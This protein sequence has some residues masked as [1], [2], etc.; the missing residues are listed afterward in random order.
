[1]KVLV[2]GSGGR[3]HALVWKIA[4]SPLV[5]KIY[6]A[7]G[8]AGIST[9][10]ECVN[11]SAEDIKG[12][13]AFAQNKKI[14]LTVVGPETPLTLGIVDLF[15]AKKLSIFGPGKE[16][17][18]IEGSKVFAK[19]LM[20]KYHIPT[21]KYEVFTSTNKA[22][23]YLKKAE[24]PLVIKADGLAAG[25]GVIVAQ[26]YEE[27]AAAV[28]LIIQKKAFG[29]AGNK[30]IIEEFLE[31]EEVSFMAVTDG[32][33]VLPLATSQDHKAIFDGDRGPNT[34][35]MGAYSPAP[36]VTPQLHKQIMEEVMQ[37]T[38]KA[39]AAEG[40][41]Y[42]G[43]LY[44]GLIIKEGKARVLEFNGRFGDPEAQPILARMKS[45]LV[46]IMQAAIDSTLGGLSIDWDPRP[47]VCVVMASQGYPG[48]YEKGEV[49]QGLATVS[50]MKDV[51]VFHAGTVRKG[52]RLATSG[53]RVLGVTALGSDI[54]EA[55]DRVY[56]ATGRIQWEGVYFRKDIGHKALKKQ[57]NTPLVGIVMGSDSDLPIMV[58]TTSVL[59]KMDI[60]YELTIASAHRSPQ[61][62]HEYAQKAAER[63]LEI[64]IAGAGAAAHL[65]GVIA[66]E[67]T[68]PVIGVPIN[69]SALNGLDSLLSTVQM[70]PGVPVATMAIGKAGAR[71]A[72]IFAA[73]IL[74]LKY[75][76]IAEELRKH[77]VNMAQEV[78][79]KANRLGPV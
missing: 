42:R 29:E 3:E 37:P 57:E 19:K 45:D 49:I 55:I 26:S 78:E 73:Q 10:A 52:N 16:A 8:N 38:F 30:I 76:R 20:D 60:P 41:P 77:K 64:I 59:K 66:S 33:T 50:K 31:G 15:S 1:M 70:P 74:S 2:V 46:E 44:A 22:M 6:C 51:I 7:P 32:K 28:D 58:E 54:K 69:S 63:G 11:I 67:T 23:A 34:G 47:A 75:P 4:R 65:A 72:A 24:F 39:L 62:T 13:C 9:L 68:L 43:V 36:L 25:K 14:D 56:E 48:N 18:A 61:R 5:K 21:G 35:G 27:G 71:N 17:A 40:R 53:G 79:E 12:L